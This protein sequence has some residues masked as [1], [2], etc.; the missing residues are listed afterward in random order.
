MSQSEPVSAGQRVGSKPDPSEITAK[1]GPVTLERVDKIKGALPWD[2][3]K[4]QSLCGD[5]YIS[6]TNETVWVLTIEAKVSLSKFRRLLQEVD[7]ASSVHIT[8]AAKSGVVALDTIQ[9]ERDDK[10]DSVQT[11]NGEEPL[12]RI[13]VQTQKQQINSGGTLFG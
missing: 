9:Y 5:T 7:G 6:D 3:N 2:I 13:Q 10:A 12:Y 4:D 11:E 1:V 8:T